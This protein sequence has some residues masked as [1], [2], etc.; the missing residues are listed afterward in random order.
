[1]EYIV[2]YMVSIFALQALIAVRNPHE[3]A[4]T[5]FVGTVIWPVMLLIVAVS[6]LLDAIGVGFDM[7]KSPKMF[8]ARRPTNTKIRGFALTLFY[9]EIQMWKAR[10]A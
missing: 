4:R 1:M 9:I 3:D 5:M 6:F 10:K 7:V 2:G 8:N